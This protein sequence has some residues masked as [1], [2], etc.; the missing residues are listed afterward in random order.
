MTDITE[1]LT[2][3]DEID[4][5]LVPP[6]YESTSGV[7]HVEE[8]A[9]RMAR[10]MTPGATPSTF[11]YVIGKGKG[12]VAG[13]AYV[14]VVEYPD[15]VARSI[16]MVN[17]GADY[18]LGV[19]TGQATGD[20]RGGFTENSVESLAYPQTG[21]WT[22]MRQ[23]F[24]LSD[25]FQGVKG[26]KGVPANVGG[27]PVDYRPYVPADGFHVALFQ[28]KEL[29]DARS[30]GVAVGK[31]KLFA[32]PD[33]T[34]LY[35]KINY[36]PDGLPRRRI[37]WREEMSDEIVSSNVPTQRGVTNPIDWHV[38][39]MRMAKIL[40]INTY[41]KDLLEF[42]F[43][44][45]W[46]AG[47]NNWM[48]NAQPPLTNVWADIVP[49]ATEEGLEVLPYFEYKTGIG[50]ASLARERR[51]IKLYDGSKQVCGNNKAYTCVTWTEDHDGD[52]TDPDTLADAKRMLDKTVV[53]Y[54]E[55]GAFAGIWLRP[56]NTHLPIGF[57]DATIARFKADRTGDAQAQTATRPALIASYEGD[58]ALYNKYIAWWFEK[59]AAFLAE[60]QQYLAAQLGNDD[61]QVLYTTVASEPLPH[62]HAPGQPFGHAGVVTDD[63]AWWT[64]YT[65][66]VNDGYYKWHLM[67]SE[68][69]K[70][71]GE[72]W[73]GQRLPE[74]APITNESPGEDYHSAPP[75]DPE[76]FTDIDGVMMTYPYGRQ[77]TVARADVLDSYRAKSGLTMVRMYPLNEDNADSP[78]LPYA[79]VVGYTAVNSER[80]G[81]H[82][83]LMQ[84]RAV[85]HGDPRNLAY[86]SGSSFSTADPEVMRR[87]NQAFLAVPALPSTVIA[88]ATSDAEVV[89]REI[90]TPSAGTYYYVVNASM[91]RKTGIQVTL[92]AGSATNLVTNG[93]DDF[94]KLELASG[95]L[96]AYRVAP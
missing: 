19:A 83:M 16:Y 44:Q 31:I 40:G 24:H 11:A 6:D 36:P 77:F 47:D 68:Y 81:D 43:N 67:P 37:F 60:L 7:S 12:L 80:G 41:A 17:R 27:Q 30:H 45:G 59:R 46:D 71:V 66:T 70:V 18:M 22:S 3:V 34:E 4:T 89:V 23:V 49:K 72:N 55:T 57:G 13:A 90:K 50:A 63:P 61:V 20:A 48:Y 14:L 64:S 39:K 69:A 53:A 15:D 56:R 42:G 1:G 8:V 25:R 76:N 52:V 93:R 96:R 38:G 73:Y 94:A 79:G 78:S 54:K 86:L 9:G 82:L 74:Q 58:K 85:A 35:A 84:A 62:L 91:Q 33:E 10:V 51:A 2:L 28:V 29:D 32:I 75:G 88:D 87:F 21:A 95:E 26:V 92:P 65:A 5:A